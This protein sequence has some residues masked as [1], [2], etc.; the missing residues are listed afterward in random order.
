[1]APGL[2]PEREPL[3]SVRFDGAELWGDGAE[4]GQVLYI[5]LSESYLDPA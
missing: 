1:M 2:P 5:D 4:P 3:Y